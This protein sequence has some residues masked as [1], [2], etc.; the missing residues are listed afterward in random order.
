[1]GVRGDE[2]E[3]EKWEEE[4]GVRGD[5]DVDEKWEEGVGWG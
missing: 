1:M 5:E 2:D 3:D 4:V